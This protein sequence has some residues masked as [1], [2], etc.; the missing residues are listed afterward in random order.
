MISLE[1]NAK[2][3]VTDSGGV[4]KEAYFNKIPCIT[5]RENTDWVETV[6]EGVNK[7][8]G[9]NPQNIKDSIINFSPPEQDYSKQLYGDG[10]TSEKIVKILNQY[11]C[12]R[13]EAISR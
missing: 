3:N 6:K 4:Q 11:H 2:K 13:S 12:E 8:A 1:A 10:K 7:L 9:V 5:F